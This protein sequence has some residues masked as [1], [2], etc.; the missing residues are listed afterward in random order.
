MVNGEEEE[1]YLNY[2]SS[3]HSGLTVLS[4]FK[5]KNN[6][7]IYLRNKPEYYNMRAQGVV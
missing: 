6:F 3:L 5:K 2:M 7:I 1:I 4:E